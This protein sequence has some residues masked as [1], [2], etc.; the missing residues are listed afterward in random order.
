MKLSAEELTKLVESINDSKLIQKQ[1]RLL[2]QKGVIEQQQNI[3]KIVETLTQPVVN[4]VQEQ[5]DVSKKLPDEWVKISG[6]RSNNVKFRFNS[7]KQLGGFKYIGSDFPLI[8]IQKTG[9]DKSSTF[10]VPNKA[11]FN[12]FFKKPV[13]ENMKYDDLVN[14]ANIVKDIFNIDL[15]ASNKIK[16]LLNKL[17]SNEET[18]QPSPEVDNQI[19]DNQIDDNQID[20][21]QIDDN[22]IDDNQI[23]DNQLDDK[24]IGE[25]LVPRPRGE[26]LKK[27]NISKNGKLLYNN[28]T[29]FKKLQLYLLATEAGHTNLKK[30]IKILLDELLIRQL[31]SKPN[32]KKIYKKYVV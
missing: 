27:L 14:Y 6:N 32:H 15:S 17:K 4:K 30:D 24:Q 12:L 9:S 8:E 16:S 11:V 3:D 31:I 29:L 25:G 19:S 7:K 10:K 5:I 20:D 1:N 2:K 28:K 13:V 21:N 22:Q 26:G 23:D 18:P